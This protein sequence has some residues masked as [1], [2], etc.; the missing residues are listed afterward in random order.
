ML[1]E[2]WNFH[3]DIA[4]PLEGIASSYYGDFGRPL[5]KIYDA[6]AIESG[7]FVEVMI[8]LLRAKTEMDN[9]CHEI[10]RFIS[11]CRKYYGVNGNEIPKEEAQ[12]LFDTFKSL[13][14]Q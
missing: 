10:E 8:A 12:I 5:T 4:I 2:F 14:N 11:E 6:D 7:S 13:Y 3:G 1:R 9:G